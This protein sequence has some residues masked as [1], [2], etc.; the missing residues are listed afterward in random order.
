MI[1]LIIFIFGITF[2]NL[3]FPLK[4]NITPIIDTTN[5]QTAISSLPLKKEIKTQTVNQVIKKIPEQK[6][7]Q[8]VTILAGNT[9]VHLSIPPNTAFYDALLQAKNAGKIEFSG[10]NYLGLGFMVTDIGTLHAGGGK[11]LL[12]YINGK[13]ASIGVSSYS[14]KDGDIIEWKLE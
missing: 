10:K 13:Q 14:L 7:D 8:S 12:Y 2:F 1:I 5:T 9:T 4:H 11:N 3:S 6:N